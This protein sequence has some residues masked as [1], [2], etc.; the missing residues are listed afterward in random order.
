MIIGVHWK[1]TPI[2]RCIINVIMSS[3][4]QVE[5]RYSHICI[6]DAQVY[7]GKRKAHGPHG[8]AAEIIF[9][10]ISVCIPMHA[11]IVVSL[12]KI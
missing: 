2:S 3:I 12:I 1:C 7:R 10:K 11:D 9:I 6:I 5:V 4:H 8:S